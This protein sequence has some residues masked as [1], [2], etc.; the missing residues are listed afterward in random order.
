MRCRVGTERAHE[1]RMDFTESIIVRGTDGL[2]LDTAELASGQG[3]L[4]FEVKGT[5]DA[6][7]TIRCEPQLDES[8]VPDTMNLPSTNDI[9]SDQAR[10]VPTLPLTV[11]LGS[12]RNTKLKLCGAADCHVLVRPTSPPCNTELLVFFMMNFCFF[13][14]RHDLTQAR[15]LPQQFKSFWINFTNGSLSLGCG[16]RGCS[17]LL[18]HPVSI[19]ACRLYIGF[20]SLDCPVAFR[21]IILSPPLTGCRPLP[22][23]PK[24][25][26]SISLTECCLKALS[27]SIT[28][29]D[30][31]Q[32]LVVLD[33]TW[34]AAHPLW[35]QSITLL[36]TN[37]ATVALQSPEA[38]MMLPIEAVLQVLT[39]GHL[40]TPEILLFCVVESWALQVMLSSNDCALLG[41]GAL[42]AV[43]GLPTGLTESG[44]TAHKEG[45]IGAHQV[46]TAARLAMPQQ[47][48]SQCLEHVRFPL[49]SI[50]ESA[51]AQASPLW[52][53][54]PCAQHLLADMPGSREKVRGGRATEAQSQ[55]M[56]NG[57][58]SSDRTDWEAVQQHQCSD[59]DS[60]DC[61]AVE[62][63][64]FAAEGPV[65]TKGVKQTQR[66]RVV[67]QC[68]L[69]H[70][71]KRQRRRPANVSVELHMDFPGDNN[72]L[73]RY[74]GSN[75]G[76]SKHFLNP[77]LSGL[78]N[79]SSS[80]PFNSHSD[81]KKLLSQAFHSSL[82]AHANL[83]DSAF[84]QLDF[85]PRKLVCLQYVFGVNQSRSFPRSWR[86]QGSNDPNAC[87][88]QDLHTVS[89][90]EVFQ[91]QGQCGAWPIQQPVM[92]FFSSIRLIM[93]GPASDGGSV[94]NVNYMELYGY[95]S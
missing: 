10:S 72:G 38:L 57:S 56:H 55:S 88:W 26:R 2:W 14:Q 40:C 82:C 18:Q 37:F 78:V 70:R 81:P 46:R 21:S 84:W 36:A 25:P 59:A 16:P 87:V 7:I 54:V 29:D 13:V 5:N 83:S 67:Q 64:P 34:N 68:E 89:D 49:M 3:C 48:V 60:M 66:A 93:A 61:V 35:G 12:H 51:R 63:V 43:P 62:P 52:D 80:S 4:S 20:F 76:Q 27:H 77:H 15:L 6:N 19:P 65:A 91:R 32:V 53:L 8:D 58:E 24:S 90:S 74:L 30:V 95:L 69:W 17:C 85:K 94:L 44:L 50:E 39:C 92:E 11:V 28:A 9:D 22:T 31:C 1:I 71:W 79:V 45:D 86:L 23:L 75:H 73:V 47:Q 33:N 42:P 41:A